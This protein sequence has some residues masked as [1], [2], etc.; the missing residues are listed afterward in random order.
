MLALSAHIIYTD[1]QD[2]TASESPWA[3]RKYG[4]ANWLVQ[5]Q[6]NHITFPTP[7][8]APKN[9]AAASLYF[10]GNQIATN[11]IG[12]PDWERFGYNGAWY[13]QECVCVCMG[14]CACVSGQRL[15]LSLIKRLTSAVLIFKEQPFPSFVLCPRGDIINLAVELVT[16]TKQTIYVRTYTVTNAIRADLL[17]QRPRFALRLPGKQINGRNASLSPFYVK[18]CTFPTQLAAGIFLERRSSLQL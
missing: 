10:R 18:N 2:V 3:W 6:H 5:R 16:V 1:S 14:V 4:H 15:L 7:G 8:D 9:A 13:I 12:R 11:S 17:T